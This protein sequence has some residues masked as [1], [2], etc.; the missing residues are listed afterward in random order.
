MELLIYKT[1]TAGKAISSR[2]WRENNSWFL[3]IF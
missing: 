3:Q 1:L 2:I